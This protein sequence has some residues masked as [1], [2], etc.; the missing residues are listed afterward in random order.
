ML[1]NLGK[2]PI[3]SVLSPVW[4]ISLGFM[5]RLTNFSSYALQNTKIWLTNRGSPL[6]LCSLQEDTGVCVKYDKL[7]SPMTKNNGAWTWMCEETFWLTLPW[8]RPMSAMQGPEKKYFLILSSSL[9]C[10]GSPTETFSW[11]MTTTILRHI[12]SKW[13]F[14]S[15]QVHHVA[16]YFSIF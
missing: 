15:H 2:Y 3:N 5:S 10:K 6:E 16:G 11:M 14:L 7:L 12:Y 13:C 4:L 9:S 8:E 1:R